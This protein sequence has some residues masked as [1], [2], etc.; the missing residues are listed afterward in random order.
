M[1]GVEVPF[2]FSASMFDR[3][4]KASGFLLFSACVEAGRGARRR[5]DFRKLR[6][7]GL[8]AGFVTRLSCNP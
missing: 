6:T 5:R 2:K 1:Q 4:P 7:S 3:H 8:A